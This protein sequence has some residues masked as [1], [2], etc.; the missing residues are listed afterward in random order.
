MRYAH[1]GLETAEYYVPGLPADYVS[2]RYGIPLA[3]ISKLGSAENPYGSSPAALEAVRDNLETLHLYPSW[4]ADPLR[5]KIADTYFH[6]AQ[7][8]RSTWTN[9]IDMR[10]FSD[11]PWWNT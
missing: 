6:I 7:Q 8:H 4:T 10:S 11:M 3:E 2:Q 5:E 1:V 9:E